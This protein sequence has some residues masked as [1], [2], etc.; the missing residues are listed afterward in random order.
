MGREGGEREGVVNF[1]ISR[2]KRGIAV[3]LPIYGPKT[4]N[5]TC[6]KSI[7]AG[8]KGLRLDDQIPLRGPQQTVNIPFKLLLNFLTKGIHLFRFILSFFLRYLERFYQHQF[9][10]FIVNIQ[11]EES[12]CRS[13]DFKCF[14]TF[15]VY[16]K[17]TKGNSLIIFIKDSAPE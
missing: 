8:E 7:K 6:K 9:M 10:E 1:S 13:E 12:W 3:S 17:F 11:F 2:P 15:H 4:D 5:L 16:L 14:L